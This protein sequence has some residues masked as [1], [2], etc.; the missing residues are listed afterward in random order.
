MTTPILMSSDDTVLSGFSL[1]RSA[2]LHRAQE[3]QC[4]EYVLGVEVGTIPNLF[5]ALSQTAASMERLC[6][7]PLDTHLGTAVHGYLAAV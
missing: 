7:N 2:L 1:W 3:I 4:I 5:L 6:A